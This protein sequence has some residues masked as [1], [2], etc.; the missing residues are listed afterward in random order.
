MSI[1]WYKKNLTK[2]KNKIVKSSVITVV[3][4]LVFLFWNYVVGKKF[5]WNDYE[6]FSTPLSWGFLSALVFVGPGRW[7][8]YKGFYLNLWKIFKQISTYNNYKKTKKVIWKLLVLIMLI[9]VSI[10]V[11]I[12]N[13]ITSF[14]LNTLA[15]ILYLSPIIGITIII[16]AIIKFIIKLKNNSEGIVIKSEKF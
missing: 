12:L 10:I 2:H 13:F 11:Y 8:F 1:S 16:Y 6:L 15:L 14:L 7:L 9:I 5:A 3:F 4:I